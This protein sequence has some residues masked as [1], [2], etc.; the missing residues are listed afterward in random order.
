MGAVTWFK[1]PVPTGMTERV[2]ALCQVLK[3]HNVDHKRS[4]SIDPGKIIYDD[5]FQI[6]VIGTTR[7]ADTSSRGR[8]LGPT[9]A[10]SKR[11]RKDT[12]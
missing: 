5:P 4:Q 1:E 3:S 8:G 2:N 12:Q 11:S 9:S 6:G 10:G 7:V